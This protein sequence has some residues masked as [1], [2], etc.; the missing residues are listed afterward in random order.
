MGMQIQPLNSGHD[1]KH[2]DCGQPELNRWLRDMAG[3]QGKKHFSRTFVLTSDEA[4]TTI[5]GFYTL[6]AS[7]VAGKSLRCRGNFPDRIPVV[8]LGRFAVQKSHQRQGFGKH[9]LFNA[10]Q[11]V[12]DTSRHVGIAAIVIDAKE[13][14]TDF[15]C[16]SAGFIPSPHNPLQ[17]FLLTQ[18]LH[19]LMQQIS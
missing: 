10:L 4:P 8:R 15:Y 14:Q 16:H 3:Q 19:Q 12:M 9:L 13:G 7:E 5:L 1:R 18:T 17:L 6:S 11:R 2:F